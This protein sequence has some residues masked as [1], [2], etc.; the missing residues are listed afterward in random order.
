M[1]PEIVC[2]GEAL[3][4]FNYLEDG[5]VVEGFGG[6]TSNCA[7]AAARQG[8]SVGYLSAVGRDAFGDRLM[9]LW[10]RE[11]VDSQHV[12]RSERFP[13]GHYAVTHSQGGHQFTYSRAGSAASQITPADLPVD[14]IANAAAALS[15]EGYGALRPRPPVSP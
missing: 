10:A 6:D 5:S 2:L 3:V 9:G 14:Y 15:T 8:A 7:I 11:G 4:E 13:T 12:L 1:T